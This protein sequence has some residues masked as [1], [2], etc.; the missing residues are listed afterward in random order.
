VDVELNAVFG[1]G[2]GGYTVHVQFMCNASLPDGQ[3]EF[4]DMGTIAIAKVIVITARS[5]M[6]CPDYG[7]ERNTGVRKLSVGAVF[8]IIIIAGL[9]LYVSG[10]VFVNTVR[11]S[12]A[13]PNEEFWDD[14]R[15]SIAGAFACAE[16]DEK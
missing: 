10:G 11:R 1:K 16:G 6:V 5:R 2:Y 15:L 14:V 3:A 9:V 12:V 7:K 13:F 4:D 8:L